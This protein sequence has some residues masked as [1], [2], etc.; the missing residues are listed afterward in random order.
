MISQIL[1]A[2]NKKMISNFV[3]EHIEKNKFKSELIFKLYPEGKE[4]SVDQVRSIRKLLIVGAAGRRLFILFDFGRASYEAQNAL[5]KTLEEKTE[6]ND[7]VMI[8]QN[9]RQILPTIR[10]RSKLIYLR[11]EG[12]K[13]I[14]DENFTT[15]IEKIVEG[16]DF[17]FLDLQ[18][19]GTK[20]REEA[21]EFLGK[22]I[23]FFQKKLQ[24]GETKAALVLKKI[25]KTY[26]LVDE[27]N[28]NPQLAV[29][30]LLIFIHKTYSMKKD[31]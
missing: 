13:T 20:G 1:I 3:T 29:D 7:F 24:A 22:I 15:R 21:V 2:S 23:H 6:E 8:C 17:K 12:T 4:F 9:E 25:L 31:G 26:Q 30:N 28:I 27:G 11:D 16:E 18:F 5:L 14:L 19:R 10:S